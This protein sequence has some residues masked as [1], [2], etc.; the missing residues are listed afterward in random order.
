MTAE[1]AAIAEDLLI[2]LKNAIHDEF[3]ES[4]ERIMASN[5]NLFTEL[6]TSDPQG[7]AA[8]QN[9]MGLY[10]QVNEASCE[11]RGRVMTEFHQSLNAQGNVIMRKV[12][13]HVMKDFKKTAGENVFKPFYEDNMAA[14]D[15]LKQEEGQIFRK[16]KA[17]FR[18]EIKA[19]F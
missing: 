19:N 3:G 12:F 4:W 1:N 15:N 16:L 17:L 13:C 18:Q 7:W 11:E 6:Q 2:N 8:L 14:I 5:A 9:V 10:D